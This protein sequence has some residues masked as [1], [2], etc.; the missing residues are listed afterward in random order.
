V[1]AAAADAPDGVPANSGGVGVKPLGWVQRNALV[2]GSGDKAAAGC[3]RA[4]FLARRRQQ[5]CQK[6]QLHDTEVRGRDTKVSFART[7]NRG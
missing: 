2:A 6:K 7:R 3:M 4:N 1:Q 5:I